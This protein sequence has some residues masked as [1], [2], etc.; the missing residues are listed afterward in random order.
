[1]NSQFGTISAT[2][3]NYFNYFFAKVSQWPHPLLLHSHL[4]S[5]FICAQKF[6]IFS[7]AALKWEEYSWSLWKNGSEWV[8]GRMGLNLT[9][10][11]LQVKTCLFNTWVL[12]CHMLSDKEVQI[13][14]FNQGKCWIGQNIFLFEDPK[15]LYKY[16]AHSCSC[17]SKD[18]KVY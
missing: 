11:S 3:I 16:Y 9:Y 10:A 13:W 12:W 18:G 15:W 17:D 14:F 8:C 4:K 7:R 6:A 5:I 2:S 1:M